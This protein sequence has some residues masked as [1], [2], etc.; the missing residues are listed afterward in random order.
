MG[1]IPIFDV[2]QTSVDALDSFESLDGSSSPRF[3]RSHLVCFTDSLKDESYYIPI[4]S[5]Q[6]E[7]WEICDMSS[8]HV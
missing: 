7:D 6:L 8:S 3:F 4:D 1:P 2:L 5:P